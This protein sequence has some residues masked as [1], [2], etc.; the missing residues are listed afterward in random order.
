[1][2]CPEIVC[3]KTKAASPTLTR[4]TPRGISYREIRRADRPVAACAL[5][6]PREGLPIA[7]VVARIGQACRARLVRAPVGHAIVAEAEMRPHARAIANR[8]GAGSLETQ[9]NAAASL[10]PAQRGEGGAKRRMR[11]GAG[12]LGPRRS[13]PAGN[14]PCARRRRWMLPAWRPSTGASARRRPL[15]GSA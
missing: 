11:G 5:P 13:A 1:M 8:A 12:P 6:Q 10:R 4:A 14:P 3:A 7:R 9:R 15:R 2:K